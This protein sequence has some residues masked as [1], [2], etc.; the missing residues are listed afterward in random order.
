MSDLQKVQSHIMTS[1][2]DATKKFQSKNT[3]KQKCSMFSVLLIWIYTRSL[4]ITKSIYLNIIYALI[5]SNKSKSTT[6]SQC[7]DPLARGQSHIACHIRVADVRSPSLL[8]ARLSSRPSPPRSRVCGLGFSRFTFFNTSCKCKD[9][10][11]ICAF[12]ASIKK[13]PKLSQPFITVYIPLTVALAIPIWNH[14]QD[15]ISAAARL[16]FEPHWF[17][18]KVPWHVQNWNNMKQRWNKCI[19]KMFTSETLTYSILCGFWWFFSCQLWQNSNKKHQKTSIQ[20]PPTGWWLFCQVQA[21]GRHE[22]SQFGLSWRWSLQELLGR[23]VMNCWGPVLGKCWVYIIIYILRY[24]GCFSRHVNL[25]KFDFALFWAAHAD[26]PKFKVHTTWTRPAMWIHAASPWTIGLTPTR[27]GSLNHL[28]A[29]RLGQATNSWRN[30]AEHSW[31]Q[32]PH[33]HGKEPS[34]SSWHGVWRTEAWQRLG[35]FPLEV[36][37]LV[38]LTFSNMVPKCQSLAAKEKWVACRER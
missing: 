22:E 1:A 34:I 38:G 27:Q 16:A 12:S 19:S 25:C 4:D 28:G 6:V 10:T 32:A 23:Q 3:S 26:L 29:P 30:A 35:R 33:V 17:Q 21:G 20:L 8:W 14:L 2:N 9:V 18:G 31:E 13:S 11:V 7:P 15:A 36:G 37:K 24:S 5:I